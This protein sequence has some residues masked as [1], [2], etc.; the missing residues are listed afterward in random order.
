MAEIRILTGEDVRMALTMQAAI[1]A[2]REG[3]IALSTGRARVPVRGV[4][5]QPGGVTLTM[6]AHIEGA[7]ISTVK[8]VSVFPGNREKGLPAVMAALLVLDASSGEPLALLDGTALTAIRTGAA[9]GVA[10]DLLARPDAHVLGVIG[11]GP[12]A[13]TQIEAVC[14]VRPLTAI[15]IYSRGGAGDLAAEVRNRYALD[16]RAVPERR[17]ALAGAD[18]IVAAT[19]SR[20]PVITLA[21]VA[22]GTHINAVGSFTPEMQE[23]AADVVT[24]ARVVV[25]HRESAWAE[26]GD[27]IIPRDQGIFSEEEV[28]AE[29]GEIAAGIK[30]GRESQE[31]ITLFKSVGN[32][33]QDAV[34]AAVVL[35]RAATLNLGTVAAL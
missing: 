18:I 21:D 20:T 2:V 8:V 11:A 34:V 31:A 25:D 23:V 5:E 19:N 12:Q 22:P 15:R 13:R 4:F 7:A 35:E 14:A 1:G 24:N 26:A 10:T 16:A 3:F 28:Y 29:L 17:E 27:L 6:P 9:S 33:V 32:A 30:R